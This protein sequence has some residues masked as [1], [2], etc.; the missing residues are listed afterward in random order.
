VILKNI[1]GL[2][3]PEA[4]KIFVS[5]IDVTPFSEEQF[6]PIRQK[7]GLVFQ[8][9]ALF[10]SLNLFENVAF[11]LNKH[12][13]LTEDEVEARVGEVF[14]LVQLGDEFPHSKSKFPHQISYG[15]QKRISLA[16]TIVLNP[17]ILLYDEPTTGLD[18]VTTTAIT[19]L[20]KNLSRKLKITSVVIS[21]DMR[22]AL[23]IAD[24]IA[25][26][27]NG[28]ICALGTPEQM[29]RSPIPLVQEFLKE[30]D[31]LDFSEFA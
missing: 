24:R 20:I 23:G 22:C 2:M 21:H 8:Q 9:P 3:R 14:R 26:L 15:V 12:F 5:G 29:K 28:K 16:R 27:E 19:N 10:D 31:G 30:C 1:V 18:P 11:G 6:F 13:R 7:C 17:E 25:M 4:G